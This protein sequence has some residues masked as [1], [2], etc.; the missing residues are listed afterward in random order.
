VKSKEFEI[1]HIVPLSA[2]GNNEIENLQ[3]LCKDCHKQ[4]SREEKEL[5]LYHIAD[6]TASYFNKN[7]FDNVVNTNAFKVW[8][9]VEK[10]N[11]EKKD[12]NTF[13]IDMTK[14]RKNIA[15][16]SFLNYLIIS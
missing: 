2:G 11:D 13:K 5:G 7:A 9:F 4:K 8:Q 16:F 6:E 3:P 12:A 10:V 15:Y 1:D 14:C